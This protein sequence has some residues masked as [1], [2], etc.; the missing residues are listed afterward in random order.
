MGDFLA[1]KHGPEAHIEN[2][3]LDERDV[4]KE[5]PPHALFGAA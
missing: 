3:I 1:H 2:G 5:M 4:M